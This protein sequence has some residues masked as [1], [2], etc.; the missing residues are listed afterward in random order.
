MK[1]KNPPVKIFSIPPAKKK[2]PLVKINQ[3]VSVKILKKVGVKVKIPSVKIPKKGPKR[4]FTGTFDFRG[5]KNTVLKGRFMKKLFF[6]RVSPNT[7]PKNITKTCSGF[8]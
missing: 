3:I 8:Y 6:V 4:A 5:E 7:H 1:K 2:N